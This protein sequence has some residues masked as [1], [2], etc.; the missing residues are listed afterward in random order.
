MK[1]YFTLSLYEHPAA[2]P[3]ITMWENL[4]ISQKRI[5]DKSFGDIVENSTTFLVKRDD[6]IEA[7]ICIPLDYVLFD[8]SEIEDGFFNSI[9]FREKILN[10]I[11]KY[12]ETTVCSYL[13]TLIFGKVTENQLIK[14]SKI[15]REL[16]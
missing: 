10:K 13:K 6:T 16:T 8:E 1:S 9:E 12:H 14:I 7:L 3:H 15:M 4:M 2:L 11:N 5:I